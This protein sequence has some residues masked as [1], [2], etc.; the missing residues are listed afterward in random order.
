MYYV[1]TKR[2]CPSPVPHPSVALGRLPSVCHPFIIVNENCP[3]GPEHCSGRNQHFH[4]ALFTASA[5]GFEHDDPS[6]QLPRQPGESFRASTSH[7]PLN[8]TCL[9]SP[10]G[11]PSRSC[12]AAATFAARHRHPSARPPRPYLRAAQ[13]RESWRDGSFDAAPPFD[14]TTP[15]PVRPHRAAHHY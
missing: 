7:P 13:R 14:T 15:V 3:P 11:C 4:D 9:R 2:G 1:L 6:S 10:R 12:C 8:L 5:N